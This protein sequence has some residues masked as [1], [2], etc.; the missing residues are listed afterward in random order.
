MAHYAFLDQNNVVVEV[1]VGRD[2]NDLI[3]GVTSW[4]TYY[5]NIRGLRCV[6]TSYNTYRDAIV[7][8]DENDPTKIV[9]RHLSEPKHRLG[10]TPFRGQYAGIN[11]VYDETLDIFKTVENESEK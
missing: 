9:D 7:I 3:D 1:I 11:D 4:E 8:Y 5:G 10:G 6:R 2:E